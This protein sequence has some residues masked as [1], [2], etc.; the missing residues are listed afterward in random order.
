MNKISIFSRD[1][2]DNAQ[3][4]TGSQD[5]KALIYN[6]G[7]VQYNQDITAAMAII[8][9]GDYAAVWLTESSRPYDPNAIYHPLEYYRAENPLELSDEYLNAEKCAIL[10]SMLPEYIFIRGDLWDTWECEPTKTPN[11]IKAK[12]TLNL[13]IKAWRLIPFTAYYDAKPGNGFKLV[14]VSLHGAKVDAA[15]RFD[16][17]DRL[18][19]L[20][21]I[22]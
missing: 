4:I 20:P 9:D 3:Y 17:L 19:S 7:I 18:S 11:R 1:I 21:A 13:N 22:D 5:L 8:E 2:P 6:L 16:L 14:R 12:N 10:H 15:T